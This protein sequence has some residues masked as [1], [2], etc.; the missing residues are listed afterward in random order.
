MPQVSKENFPDFMKFLSSHGV[1]HRDRRVAADMM[2]P[3][4]KE[5]ETDR[6]DTVPPAGLQ[7]PIL[8]SQ[9][10][11]V[12]DGHHRW[13]HAL[14]NG[15]NIKVI[16]LSMKIRPLLALIHK[17]PKVE[18]RAIDSPIMNRESYGKFVKRIKNTNLDTSGVRSN[19]KVTED[20]LVPQLGLDDRL[21]TEDDEVVP[22]E[23]V[24]SGRNYTL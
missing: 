5:I 24:S 22:S 7:K 10:N 18:Y 19:K 6:V 15:M 2:K 17:Y 23:V 9:D 1:T 4:Q 12:I 14:K 11:Y 16:Q 8:V 13:F 3:A 20:D 21:Y